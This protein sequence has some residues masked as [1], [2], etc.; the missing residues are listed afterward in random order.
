MLQ[1]E[2][3]PSVT[4][5]GKAIQPSGRRS[6]SASL[7]FSNVTALLDLFTSSQNTALVL[8]TLDPIL[9]KPFPTSST[10]LDFLI[11]HSNAQSGGIDPSDS[12]L[13]WR[14]GT[15]Q[16][17]VVPTSKQKAHSSQMS[18][19]DVV[20]SSKSRSESRK[21]R[22]TLRKDVELELVA[23]GHLVHPWAQRP[24]ATMKERTQNLRCVKM[25]M[26]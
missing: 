19:A 21:E 20:K 26:S 14:N 9:P 5:K 12:Q 24:T 1:R 13:P 4:A 2:T 22:K 18:C 16:S 6:L 15:S 8:L 25:S 10:Q 17:T 11:A 23:M 3:P 7:V